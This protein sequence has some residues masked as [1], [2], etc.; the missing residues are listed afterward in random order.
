MNLGFKRPVHKG[1]GVVGGGGGWSCTILDM[2]EISSYDHTPQH[3]H[4]YAPPYTIPEGTLI[5]NCLIMLT[6]NHEAE[7]GSHFLFVPSISSGFPDPWV[8]R[9]VP[10]KRGT[11]LFFHALD[12]HRELGLPKASPTGVTHPRLMAFFAIELTQGANLRFPNLHLTQSIKPPHLGAPGG[13][14]TKTVPWQGEVRCRG[15]V[16]AKCYGCDRAGLCAAHKDGLCVPCQE[17]EE[18]EGG[19]EEV[20]VEDPNGVSIEHCA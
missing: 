11:A 8:E 16:V 13:R 3:L 12:V 15:K 7:D 10:F 14:V 2:A 4:R 1:Y 19:E 20:L 6:H 18:P 5:V 9:A 17:G